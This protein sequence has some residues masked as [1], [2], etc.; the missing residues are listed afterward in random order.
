[1][2][3]KGNNL[4]KYNAKKFEKRSSSVQ[5]GGLGLEA[6]LLEED[7]PPA[8]SSSFQQQYPSKQ[9]II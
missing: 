7:K 8:T 2:H 1:M 5:A 6:L 4:I 3:F 9:D